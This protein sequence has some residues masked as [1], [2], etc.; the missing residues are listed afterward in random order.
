M[1]KDYKERIRKKVWYGIVGYSLFLIGCSQNYLDNTNITTKIEQQKE[2]NI[3]TDREEKGTK[4]Q[5]GRDALESLI[6]NE[7]FCESVWYEAGL[8][9]EDSKEII[10][11]KL[12]S[13][14][15]LV[16]VGPSHGNAVFSLEGLRLMSNLKSLVIDFSIWSDSKIEDFTPI[17]ELLQLKQL[18]FSY[19]TEEALDLS[20]LAEI[21][22]I[23]ELYLPNCK[24]KDIEFL[25]RMP[26]LERLSLYETPV[27][28]LTVLEN[29]PKLVELALS[30]N[31]EAKHIEVVGKLFQIE[32][33]GLQNCGLEDIQFLSNLTKLREINLN[34]NLITD[35]TPLSSLLKLERLGA[36]ANKIRDIQ[37][38]AG[39]SN[40]YDL[41]LDQNQIQDLSALANLS[42]LNQVGISDNQIEDFSPLAE[43]EK[44]MFLSVFGNPCKDLTPV[45]Q[46]PI[47]NFTTDFKVSKEQQ[48]MVADWIKE[49]KSDIEE[50]ECMEYIEGDLNEDGRIDAAF[51]IEYNNSRDLFVLLCQEDGSWK[52]IEHDISIQTAVYG[53]MR[54]DP[55]RGLWMGNGYLLKKCEWGSSL[56]CVETEGYRYQNETLE[57]V[58]EKDVYDDSFE[59][60]YEVT[61][62]MN[63]DG[64]EKNDHYRIIMEKFRMIRKE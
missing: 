1:G 9:E 39:L 8:E 49:Y 6:Q 30:G 64:I 10:L 32:E 13:C 29:L 31:K 3:T 43:K 41:S 11:Q 4:E 44:L 24:I 55:H 53:G 7:S 61:V 58:L 45:W 12:N 51:V 23:T 40:L 15:S 22:T 50:Y 2:K 52:E 38:L 18:Y 33:L 37:Y 21:Q 34:Y 62:W 17:S 20:F 47:L 63:K 26:Q 19:D 60:S 59:N 28:D 35:L 42:Q 16:L 56:G 5:K 46:V 57:L 25:K 48:K 36:A 27:E 14:E 54:G